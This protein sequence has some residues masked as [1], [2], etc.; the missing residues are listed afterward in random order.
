MHRKKVMLIDDNEIDNFVSGQI[1]M[2][3]NFSDKIDEMTSAVEALAHLRTILSTPELFPD[4]IFLD[5]RMPVMD[6]FDFLDEF[7]KFPDS[8]RA[9]CSVV[10]LTSSSDSIDI[11]RALKYSVVKK[12][13]AKPLRES[14]LV[15]L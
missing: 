12:F 7:S 1:I 6:G 14:M 10:M 2:G 15:N 3:C 8:I 4:L 9:K 5:I 13:L 11:D